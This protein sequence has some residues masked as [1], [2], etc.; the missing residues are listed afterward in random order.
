MPL[1]CRVP[2]KH[3]MA[4]IQGPKEGKLILIITKKNGLNFGPWTQKSTLRFMRILRP[5]SKTLAQ[6]SWSLVLMALVT[7]PF[8]G[9]IA[10]GTLDA[11]TSSLP[12]GRALVTLAFLRAKR[13]DG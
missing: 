4:K 1:I 11:R 12:V 10:S 8:L 2:Y 7:G 9:R 13:V 6:S 5:Y 3:K